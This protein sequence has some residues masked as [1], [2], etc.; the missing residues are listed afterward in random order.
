MRDGRFE[1][2]YGLIIMGLGIGFFIPYAVRY[3]HRETIK[4]IQ[5]WKARRN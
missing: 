4:A 1:F 3:I 2:W 5:E